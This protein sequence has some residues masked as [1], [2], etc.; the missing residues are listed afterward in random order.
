[1]RRF[2]IEI[3]FG[4]SV[5]A[6][7]EAIA[8]AG[9]GS[10]RSVAGYIGHSSTHWVVK[11]DGSVSGGGELV[12]P[13]LDF[14]NPDDRA[15]VTR[16]VAVLAA[17]GATTYEAAGIHVHVESQGMDARQISAVARLFAKYE[18]VLYR[19]AS[20]GW[21]RIR[22]GALSYA[23][24]LSENQKKGL[25]RA[26]TD[27]A[28][29]RAYYGNTRGVYHSTSSHGNPA[30]YCGLNL[31]S[32]W[33]RGT[34]EFRIFNSSMNANRIQTYI[35]VCMAMVQDAKNGKLRSINKSTNLGD[36]KSGAADADKVFFNFLAVMRYQAG[37]ELEDY[38]NLKKFWEDSVP[39]ENIFA[40]R[41]Y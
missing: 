11:R 32:H 4:G 34:I 37:M 41:I 21:Q 23:K 27:E 17:A 7:A 14:D 36:M 35:A 39:Q 3:E 38:Q 2:G 20:S 22:S 19:L 13:P 18:D 40:G 10:S 16:A 25:A 8:D 1:M 6:V 5:T 15:Q 24:P 28:L 12:S 29:Q 9:L 26:R 33:Y 31:H 30:R